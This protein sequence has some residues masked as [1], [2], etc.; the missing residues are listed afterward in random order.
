MII[1]PIFFADDG[2]VCYADGRAK[3]IH[4]RKRANEWCRTLAP[5]RRRR[6]HLEPELRTAKVIPFPRPLS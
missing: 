1:D 2:L 3:T 6:K 5:T 4:V